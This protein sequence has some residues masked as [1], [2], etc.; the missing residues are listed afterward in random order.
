MNEY[1]DLKYGYACEVPAGTQ[2]HIL[3]EL[4]VPN[5]DQYQLKSFLMDGVSYTTLVKN[6]KESGRYKANG[7]DAIH[8]LVRL[9]FFQEDQFSEEKNIIKTSWWVVS[10]STER[11]R[12]LPKGCYVDTGFGFYGQFLIPHLCELDRGYKRIGVKPEYLSEDN[13]KAWRDRLVAECMAL[14]E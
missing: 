2:Y 8:C 9:M 11:P 3:D 13:L 14:A 4:K 12:H 10:T 1:I 7:D 5:G 6:G